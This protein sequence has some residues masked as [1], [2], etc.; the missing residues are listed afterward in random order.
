MRDVLSEREQTVRTQ[1]TLIIPLKALFFLVFKSV[2]LFI[3]NAININF[4]LCKDY[5]LKLTPLI[6]SLN[7]NETLK[8]SIKEE[9]NIE[10][11][12]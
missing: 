10:L 3:F 4:S 7:S 11:I 1:N 9:R 8:K 6:G 2:F 5:P 12:T